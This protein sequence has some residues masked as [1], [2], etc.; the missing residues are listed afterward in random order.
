M[1]LPLGNSEEIIAHKISLIQGN[2][3]VD[4]VDL[5]TS[6]SGGE[7]AES[8]IA[9]LQVKDIQHDVAL[10]V[11][12]AQEGTTGE[13]QGLTGKLLQDRGCPPRTA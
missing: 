8:D 13:P 4:I 11:L 9:A 12:Q 2:E 3:V 7:A 10:S 1:S 5:F 6:A